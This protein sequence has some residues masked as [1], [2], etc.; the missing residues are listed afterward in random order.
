MHA[1]QCTCWKF[2]GLRSCMIAQANLRTVAHAALRGS[3]SALC[4]DGCGVDKRDMEIVHFGALRSR[5]IAPCCLVCRSKTLC[6]RAS[7]MMLPDP[8]KRVMRIV[9]M[10]NRHAPPD[11]IIR[12]VTS[13]EELAHVVQLYIA[14][15]AA[16]KRVVG[17]YRVH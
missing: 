3:A 7:G 9:S 13:F 4:V 1:A 14:S 11:H 10:C 5:S 17:A 12:N 2:G 15:S 6:T 8:E 16:S